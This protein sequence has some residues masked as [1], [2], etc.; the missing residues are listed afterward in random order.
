MRLN[1]KE[2]TRDASLLLSE[3]FESEKNYSK[4]L[5]YHIQYVVYKDSIENL[6]TTKQIADL[7]TD[8]EINLREKEI[9]LLERKQLLH[10]VYILITFFFLGFALLLLLYFRQRF[11]NSRF[12]AESQKK[13]HDERISNLLNSHETK[14]LHSMVEGQEN[15]RKRL[16]QELHNH[17]GS[18]LATIKVNFNAVDENYIPN[19]HTLVT[20]IDKACSDI[21]SLSHELN[22]GISA[23][24]GLVPALQELRAHLQQANGLVVE[25][26]ASMSNEP[27]SFQNEIIVYRIIQELVS[28]VLKHAEASQMSILLT[29][30]EQESMLNILVQ[31]NGKGFNVDKEKIDKVG[32]GLNSLEQM[33]VN[34]QGLIIFDSNPVTGTTVTIDLPLL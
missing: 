26:S 14:I 29:Y 1:L 19:H 12:I 25:F 8:F 33:V 2:Q 13:E 21:R 3:V 27:I 34:M 9:A 24:F 4:A 32:M 10:R 16:A 18:L 22:M 7:R 28:N 6:E 30:F 17:L 11:I 31:D 5:R 20:L 15:E 23:D